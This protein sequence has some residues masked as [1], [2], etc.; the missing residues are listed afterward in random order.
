MAKKIIL[1]QLALDEKAFLAA[2]KN[3]QKA[4]LELAKTQKLLKKNGKE[5]SEQFIKNEIA[6]KKLRGEY[7]QQK[8]AIIALESPYAKL[9][10]RLI[11]ARKE[12]K[13]L[14][15]T[16]GISNKRLTEART[17]V[18][19][20]D[21]QL[22][23]IDKS[24]GQHQRSVGNYAG[25]LKGLATSF[26][27][28]TAVIFG[29]I[30]GLRNAIGIFTTFEKKNAELSAILQIEKNQMGALEA[31]SK[32]LGAT[33]AKTATQIVGLQISFARLGFSQQQIIDLTE[34]T[35]SGS[36]AMNSELDKTAGLVGAMVNSFDDFDA[37]D[38]PE[39]IDVLA[40]ATAKSALNFEKLEKGLPIVAGAANAAGIPFN[41][42]V[43]L[44]GK[45]S[46]AGIDVSTSSTALRNIFIEASKEGEDYSQII[47]RIKNSQNKL[48]TSFDAFGKRAAV[49]AAVLAQN[50][51]ATKELNIAL[52]NATGTAQRMAEKGLDTLSGSG[53]LFSSAWQGLILGLEDGQ[54]VF[55]KSLRGIVDFGTSLLN[56]LTPQRNFTKELENEQVSLFEVQLKIQDVNTSNEDRIKLIKELQEK[57]P[58]FLSNIDAETIGNEELSV[59]LK[60]VNDELINKIILQRN[61]DKIQKQ[62]N[63][64]SIAT[65]RLAFSRIKARRSLAKAAANELI[66]LKD[67]LTLRE[68][69]IEA[70]KQVNKGKSITD[71]YQIFR[72]ALNQLNFNHKRLNTVT[73]KGNI[74]DAERLEL[75]KALG[76]VT[77]ENNV[78]VK[79]AEQ[80]AAILAKRKADAKKVAEE[81]KAE[82]DR[83]EAEEIAAAKKKAKRTKKQREQDKIDADKAI[84]QEIADSIQRENEELQRIIDFTNRK[85]NLKNELELLDAETAD[86]KAEIKSRQDFEKHIKALEDLELLTE[87]K[88]ELEI[89]LLD[90]HLTRITDIKFNAKM[91]QIAADEKAD[92]AELKRKKALNKKIIDESI[93]LV[94]QQTRLGQALIAIKGILAAKETLIGLG[95]LKAKIVTNIGSATADIAAGTAATAKVGFPQNIPLIIGFLAQIAGIISAIKGA[96]GAAKNVSVPKFY[97]G[98]KVKGRNIPTQ[99]GG[100]NILATVKSGEVILNDKQQHRAGGDA[101]FKSIGVPGFQDGGIAGIPSTT[102]PSTQQLNT[103]EFAEILAERINDIKIVAI[104]EE[105]TEAQA[106]KVEIVDGANI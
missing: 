54:G 62:A 29:V 45:L 103:T 92:K 11:R 47:E 56:A 76:I 40:L 67:G 55:A 10:N 27:G 52:D 5:N 104:E 66:E 97:E 96:A 79:A 23:R 106:I 44:M 17:K 105:I 101:F 68:Q 12:F 33:T 49:S 98:G 72:V 93:N 65:E 35:I 88:N 61:A 41:T 102:L 90:L 82:A 19:A 69:L 78:F 2:A 20:L 71:Q 18:I 46:D 13:D 70:D 15:A 63:T 50:I 6:L 77:A 25:A 57:Y 86:E 83:I 39:I 85:T 4:I 95:V 89:L 91:K 43:S 14:A 73:E 8:K 26:L 3:T 51:D 9:S 37:V 24:V 31:E 1:A 84:Q 87:E 81:A 48:T 42:L 60:S 100:D 28:I 59:A 80:S 7:L 30:R 21:R 58:N 53:T 34:A 74:L 38:A 22:K 32:R 36:I 99:T 64:I 75:M 16:Q 94:G